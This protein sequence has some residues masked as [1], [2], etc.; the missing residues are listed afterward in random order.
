MFKT[1]A[2]PLATLLLASCSSVAASDA[3]EKINFDFAWRH[4]L[5]DP[6]GTPHKAD[7]DDSTWP[8]IDA[9]HDMLMGQRRQFIVSNKNQGYIARGSGWY[10]KHF[11]L[12]AEWENSGAVWVYIE[13]AFHVTSAWLNGKPLGATHKAGYTSFYLALH[14]S[15]SA[16]WGQ[17]NV[18]A[19]HVNASSGTGWWYEGGGLMRHLWLVRTASRVYAEPDSAWAHVALPPSDALRIEGASPDGLHT[20]QATIV[21]AASV[22]S[23]LTVSP[24]ADRVS[25]P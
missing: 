18:L 4:F 21:L 11:S 25:P 2:G 15:G 14:A 8:L 1:A 19:L 22:R 10:R 9:P 24:L 6:P 3:R 5:G 16:A 17:P 7:Y 23:E 13:G 20:R 12:P